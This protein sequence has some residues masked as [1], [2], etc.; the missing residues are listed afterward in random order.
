M[1]TTE[2]ILSLQFW[3]C[4]D[5]ALICPCLKNPT[6]APSYHANF[7]SSECLVHRWGSA[8]KWSQACVKLPIVVFDCSTTLIPSNSHFLSST[9]WSSFSTTSTECTT[10]ARRL[11][12]LGASLR[13]RYVI[14]L[15]WPCRRPF[16]FYDRFLPGILHKTSSCVLADA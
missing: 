3:S 1:L 14:T 5:I 15:Q 16:R 7:P 9:P 11:T 4:S 8:L 10:S 13:S 6:F 12:V 2:L